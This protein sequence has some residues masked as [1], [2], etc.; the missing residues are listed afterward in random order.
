MHFDEALVGAQAAIGDRT[1]DG[2]GSRHVGRI[3][4]QMEQR[5]NKRIVPVARVTSKVAPN[6]ST[7]ARASMVACGW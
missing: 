6:G 2:R 4:K 5:K 1:G 7:V 3:A